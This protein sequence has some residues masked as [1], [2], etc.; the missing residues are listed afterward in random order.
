[1]SRPRLDDVAAELRLTERRLEL[2]RK[3][4]GASPDLLR[5]PQIFQNLEP[6]QLLLPECA[7]GRRFR[8]GAVDRDE[9][10]RSPL[11]EQRA[12]EIGESQTL[13][14]AATRLEDLAL[15]PISEHLRGQV[16]ATPPDAL[17]QIVGMDLEGL[18]FRVAAAYEKVYVRIVGVV[19]IDR[20]PFKPCSEITFHV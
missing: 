5:E 13:D 15:G 11:P 3:P 18:T 4:P 20:H 12:V 1:M 10:A 16:L 2:R 6:A 17:L 8:H 9:A 19:V 14:G 7:C